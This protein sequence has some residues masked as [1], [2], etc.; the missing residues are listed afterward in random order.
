MKNVC[1]RLLCGTLLISTLSA[2]PAMAQY[3][4]S[5]PRAAAIRA[6]T[7]SRPVEPPMTRPDVPAQLSEFAPGGQ[8][9]MVG[10]SPGR[11]DCGFPDGE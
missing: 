4:P 3:P 7:P 6:V 10:T 8:P 2:E 1:R 9:P 5:P 11:L